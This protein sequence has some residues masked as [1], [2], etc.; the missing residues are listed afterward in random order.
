MS[1]ALEDFTND[2][3]S[4]PDIVRDICRH[5]AGAGSLRT[6]CAQRRLSYGMVRQFVSEGEAARAY[7]NALVIRDD[8][9]KDMILDEL[10]SFID[11]DLTRAFDADGNML[12]MELIPAN[13]RRM[14]S[15]I[16]FREIFE[17]R[18]T[19]E[20]RERVH[21]GNLIEI[22]LIDKMK[23]IELRARTLAMLTDKTQ[24]EMG[25]TLED[26]IRESMQDGKQAAGAVRE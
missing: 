13:I 18:G 15:G 8:H 16:K 2:A 9:A 4:D 3:L 17:N 22:K 21:V 20:D 11:S 25:A 1:Q 5:I 10:E 24:H 6:F 19:G 12:R 26:I 7:A 14:I 23:A